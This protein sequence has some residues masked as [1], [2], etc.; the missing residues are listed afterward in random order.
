[1]FNIPKTDLN[2][3]IEAMTGN[4]PMEEETLPWQK[5]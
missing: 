3:G 5:Q 1:M 2:M 4:G